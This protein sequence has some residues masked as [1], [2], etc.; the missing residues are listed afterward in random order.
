[1]MVRKPVIRHII[2]DISGT[3]NHT[4]NPI[5]NTGNIFNPGF[6]HKNPMRKF[7]VD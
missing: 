2:L 1:M 4:Q 6:M 7:K 3:S 5:F